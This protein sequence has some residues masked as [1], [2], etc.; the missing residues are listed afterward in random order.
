MKKQLSINKEVPPAIENR[1]GNIACVF[2]YSCTH[3]RARIY[4]YTYIC[5]SMAV[6]ACVRTHL[7]IY[8]RERKER[9]KRGVVMG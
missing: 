4:L 2:L 5:T 3:T 9:K 8:T 7:F 1:C 6:C